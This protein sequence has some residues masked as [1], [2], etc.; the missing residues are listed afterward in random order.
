MKSDHGR[1]PFF[2]VQLEVQ[3]PWSIFSWKQ[4]TKPLGLSLGVNRMWTKKNDHA[5]K[6][7]VLKKINICS[8][9]AVLKKEKSSLTIL[10]SSLGLHLSSLLVECVEDVACKSSH[11]NFFFLLRNKGIK[12]YMW[13]VPYVVHWALFATRFTMCTQIL[14][15]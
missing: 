14:E 7:D 3:L 9:R 5:Q 10:L 11:N 8:K 6:V 13:H 4:F 15:F 12:L 2:M 1:L